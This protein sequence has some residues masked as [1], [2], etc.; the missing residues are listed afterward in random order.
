M[1]DVIP[2]CVCIQ[3]EKPLMKDVKKHIIYQ[4]T[5]TV[6]VVFVHKPV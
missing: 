5:Q 6:H 3:T 4:M 1:S 2:I